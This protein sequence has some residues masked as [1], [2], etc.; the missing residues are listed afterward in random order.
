MEDNK[1]LDTNQNNENKNEETKT[2]TAEEVQE[3]LQKEGDRRVSEALK[4]AEK[5]KNEAIKEAQKLAQMN[6]EEKYKYELDQREKAIAEK[7]RALALAENKAQAASVLADKGISAKLVDFVVAEDAGTM[8]ENIKLLEDEFKKSVK[9][10]VEKRL[11]SN[12][13]KKNLGNGDMTRE[14]FMKLP[15][16]KQQEIF[17]NNPTLYNKMVG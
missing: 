3:L 4:K 10:E 14:E 16:V 13:P 5:K 11:S 7:E 2:Y 1:N 15:T 6:E 9:A 12:S 8:M 17:E